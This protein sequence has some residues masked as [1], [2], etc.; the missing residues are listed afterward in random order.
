[1]N[2]TKTR[3]LLIEDD[4]ELGPATQELLCMMGYDVHWAASAN[5]A[6][7]EIAH[8]GFRAALLDLNLGKES[9]VRLV[10]SLRDTG[11]HVPPL[12]IVSA[13]APDDL[14]KAARDTG[15]LRIVQKPYSM[16][17][18]QKALEGVLHENDKRRPDDHVRTAADMSR[19]C[20]RS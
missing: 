3:I 8:D 16:A 7:D 1:M 14:R 6:F 17:E 5:A 9:G 4:P 15:A 2:D 20:D 13:Q 11:H 18:L 10:C 12:I 19:A